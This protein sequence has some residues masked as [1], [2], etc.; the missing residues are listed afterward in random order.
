MST[1][2]VN[3]PRFNQAVIALLTGLAFVID[4]PWLVLVGFVILAVSWAG[5]PR[6]A[7]LTRFYV[8]VI[9]PRLSGPVVT[10]PAAP[11][12]FSQLIGAGFL[13]VASLAF[14]VG[15]SALGWGL[16]LTVTA[17]AALDATTRIC[18]GCIVY[19]KVVAP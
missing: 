14:A 9:R 1:V 12:R 7:P 6:L 13:G 11:P 19:R 3:I 10:E 2:D 16:T 17:L 18:V 15:A 4:Q 8:G 5:G